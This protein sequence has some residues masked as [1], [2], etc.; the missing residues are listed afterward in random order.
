MYFLKPTKRTLGAPRFTLVLVHHLLDL[1]I[2][3]RMPNIYI[4]RLEHTG[5]QGPRPRP[6]LWRKPFHMSIFRLQI[7]QIFTNFLSNAT[8]PQQEN[9]R[10]NRGIPGMVYPTRCIRGSLSRVPSQGYQ[11]FPCE[12]RNKL[13]TKRSSQPRRLRGL[14]Q[15]LKKQWQQPSAVFCTAHSIHELRCLGWKM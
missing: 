7:A 9:T 11:H 12:K 5:G 1:T 4:S 15:L 6:Y 13:K 2:F 3:R 10:K 8:T 14:G